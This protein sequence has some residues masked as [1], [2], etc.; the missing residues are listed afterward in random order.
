MGWG[1]GVGIGWPNSTSGSGG[2]Y[3]F[4]ILDCNGTSRTVYSTSSQFLPNA[5][6]FNDPELTD[7]FANDGYWNLPGLIDSIGGYTMA[8]T[9]E[10]GD[11][12]TSCPT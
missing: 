6:V 12:L 1:I 9:G 8:G 11:T 10:V 2:V 3:E 7:P 5:Y 4:T